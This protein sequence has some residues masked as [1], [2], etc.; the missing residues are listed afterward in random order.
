MAKPGTLSLQAEMKPQVQNNATAFSIYCVLPLRAA[1]F[2][3]SAPP[4]REMSPYGMC[5]NPPKLCSYFNMD[6]DMSGPYHE[7]I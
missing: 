1:R 4:S 7:A 5:V 2:Q 6:L 3:V